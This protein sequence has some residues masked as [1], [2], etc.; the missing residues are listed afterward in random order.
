MLAQVLC[1]CVCVVVDDGNVT[2]V[3]LPENKGKKK[4]HTSSIL[5]E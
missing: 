4:N 3:G 5:I 2:E 1:V